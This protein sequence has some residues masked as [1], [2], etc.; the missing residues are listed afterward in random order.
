MFF[1][2]FGQS[3]TK[4][5]VLIRSIYNMALSHGEAYENLREL[6]KDIGNRL[7]G[8]PGADKAVEW[9]KDKLESYAFDKVYLQE[10]I[11]PHWERG[12]KETAWFKDHQGN[13]T[14][15]HL[16]SLG[17]SVPTQGLLSA[18]VIVV[19]SFEELKSLGKSNIDGKIVFFNKA[20]DPNNIITFKSYGGCYQQRSSGAHVAAQYG[21]VGVLVR[22][23]S[24]KMDY[25]PHTGSLRYHKDSIKIPAA[26][27]S[28]RDAVLLMKALK[29]GKVTVDMQLNCKIYPDKTSY[30]VIG[31]IT[32]TEKP[33]E[34]ILI[35]GHLDSWDV[36]E[37]AHD[38][39]A[40][41]VHSI[42]ALRIIK[43]IGYKPKRTLRCV[44]FMNEENG[45]RGGKTYAKIVKDTKE[46]HIAALE[47]DRGGFTPRGF[48]LDGSL[49]QLKQLQ[50]F[51]TLLKPYGLHLFEKGYGGVDIGPLKNG[52][53][54]LIGFVPDSQRYFDHHHAQTDVFEAINERE[55]TLG[56]AACA[57][58]LYLID[59]KDITP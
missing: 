53:I 55:L 17:G 15:L 13:S 23:L 47:S 58:L 11:V 8:S 49:E 18:E 52:S 27:I 14:K 24:L 26:A 10:V 12:T 35:G 56:A 2:S 50:S 45:N 5:S 42:E 28:T 38:D 4:D 34:I 44:L 1:T 51:E 19:K 33:E 21:A 57:S 25:Y 41:V 6:C 29:T 9:G 46:L 22:S 54:A 16:L 30:N 43:A 39:G 31:E 3:N 32:G 36:G 7:T 40:G 37:G 20:M 59:Q 48:S